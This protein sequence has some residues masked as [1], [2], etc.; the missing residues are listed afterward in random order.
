MRK[1]T[2]IRI[3]NKHIKHVLSENIKKR[4]TYKNIFCGQRNY[5]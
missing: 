2:D 4:K 5:F 3:K 1:N